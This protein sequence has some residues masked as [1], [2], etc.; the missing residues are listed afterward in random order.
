MKEGLV[1]HYIKNLAVSLAPQP[2]SILIDESKD[3][4]NNFFPKNLVV[5]G[6]VSLIHGRYCLKPVSGSSQ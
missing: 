6:Q 2:F 4:T 5:L 1:P 3:A